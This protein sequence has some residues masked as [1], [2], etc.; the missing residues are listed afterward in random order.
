[1]TLQD[2][3][4]NR[5]AEKCV[6]LQVIPFKRPS[7]LRRLLATS[8]W[9]KSPAALWEVVR[10]KSLHSRTPQNR[11]LGAPFLNMAMELSVPNIKWMAFSRSL[12][13]RI[14]S[15]QQSHLTENCTHSIQRHHVS[16]CDC[17]LVLKPRRP[18]VSCG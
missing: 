10:I 18:K 15:P 1:M 2:V 3:R 6:L 7:S 4:K 9:T 5:K 11:Q 16:I 12:N 17:T 14:N 13:I 8:R